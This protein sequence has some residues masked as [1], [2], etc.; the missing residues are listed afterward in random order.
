MSVMKKIRLIISSVLL[1]VLGMSN[2]WAY[3]G[4]HAYIGVSVGPHWGPSYYAPAP[5]YPAPYYQPYYPPYY[6]PVVVTA[7]APPVYVQQT[8]VVP[9]LP[10]A[11]PPAPAPIEY[12]YYCTAS[13]T[14]YPYVKDCPAGWQKVPQQPPSPR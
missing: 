11:S 9:A 13:K 12:W 8:E 10:V 1:G 2:A 7:P 14:Y 6:P 3:H 5:Y 4:G